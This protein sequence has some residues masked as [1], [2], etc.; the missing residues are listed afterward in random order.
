MPPQSSTSVE[1]HRRSSTF[2]PVRRAAGGAVQRTTN[3]E[4]T[5]H[6]DRCQAATALRI[7][8][9]RRGDQRRITK[10]HT[11]PNTAGGRFRVT[12]LY[13][14]YEVVDRSKPASSLLHYRKRRKQP[15]TG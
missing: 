8:T 12:E 11:E 1:I 15:K 2:C 3:Q 7:V 4:D 14:K 9:K 13:A 10:P 5:D 6:R